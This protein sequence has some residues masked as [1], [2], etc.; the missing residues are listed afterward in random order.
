MAQVV[1]GATSVQER[2]SGRGRECAGW[3]RMVGVH[4][5]RRRRGSG[6]S[7]GALE[8]GR[9]CAMQSVGVA[10]AIDRD[11]RDCWWVRLQATDGR[12]HRRVRR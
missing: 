6:S 7:T 4:H 10:G 8:K 12:R 3:R 5:G 1:R 11:D 9:S 2:H